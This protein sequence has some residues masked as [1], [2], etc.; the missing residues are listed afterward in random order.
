MG[1]NTKIGTA[2]IKV[3]FITA[4]NSFELQTDTSGQ[5]QDDLTTKLKGSATNSIISFQTTNEMQDDAA[6]FRLVLAPED[7]TRWDR[8][9]SPNDIVTIQVNPGYKVD[10]DYIMVGL[11]DTVK[12]IGSYNEDSL[13]Y[14]IEGKSMMKALMQIKLGTIQEAMSLLGSTGWM[15]GMGGLS[16]ANT[17]GADNL[18]GDGGNGGEEGGE[19]TTKKL[20]VKALNDISFMSTELIGIKDSK[21]KT[22]KPNSKGDIV[23][24]SKESGIKD[25]ERVKVPGYGTHKAVL[26]KNSVTNNKLPEVIISFKDK[27]RYTQYTSKYKGEQSIEINPSSSAGDK[28]DTATPSTG[29]MLAGKTAHEVVQELVNW[30]L[31]L[32]GAGNTVQDNP[33]GESVIKYEYADKERGTLSK[34]LETDLT[35]RSEDEYLTDPTPIMSYTG[36]LR[37]LIDDVT[38]RP[39]NELYNEFTPDGKMSIVMRPTPFE[40]EQW[41]EL[42]AQ[43]VPLNAEDVIEEATSQSDN[44]AFSIFSSS[45]PSSIIVSSLNSLMMFPVYY[46][47]LA[48]RYGYSMLQQENGYIF[49]TNPAKNKSGGGSE[50]ASSI[51]AGSKDTEKNAKAIAAYLKK[52][53]YKG[54]AIAALL[55][56]L[57]H[58]SY[59]N[60]DQGEAGNGIGYGIAQW[61]FERRKNLE[62]YAKGKGKKV[63]DLSV[64]VEFMLNHDGTDSDLLRGILGKSGS[65]DSLT[66]EICRR[67]ER[68]NMAVAQLG[69]RQ[70]NAKHWYKSL[71]LDSYTPGK[72]A[73]HFSP[74][75]L[76]KLAPAE[77]HSTSVTSGKNPV[78]DAMNGKKPEKQDDR[79]HSILKGDGDP[80]R[81]T[82]PIE[83]RLKEKEGKKKKKDN[84]KKKEEKKKMDKDNIALSKKYSIFLANWYGINPSFLSGDI[85]VIGSPIYRVGQVLKRKD[86]G[87]ADNDIANQELNPRIID[88]YIEGVSH[89]FNFEAGYTT[90]LHVTRGLPEG[91]TRDGSNQSVDRFRYWND[92]VANSKDTKALTADKPGNG[93]LQLFTGGLFGEMSIG[94]AVEY[95]AQQNGGDDDSGDSSSAV[96]SPGKDS[97]PAKWKNAAQDSTSDDWGYYNRECVSYVAWKLNEAG[98]NKGFSHLGNAISWKG[99]GSS[100]KEPKA[101]DVAWFTAGA[102]NGGVGSMGHVGYVDKVM[103]DKILMSDYNAGDPMGRYNTHEMSKDTPTSY[104]RFH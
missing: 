36:S 48:E 75:N 71:K 97:Y 28:D 93:D 78:L 64:Q 53:G 47:A 13:L 67:W 19:P 50:D 96:A 59:I 45:M 90:T 34:W 103:G 102:W 73:V 82:N 87:E 1:V 58:E 23:M 12:K 100:H 52:A 18:E 7:G 79:V 20:H 4:T 74:A 57:Q 9:L 83:D 32:E 99:H 65:V 92:P 2:T 25:G 15:M 5:K 42:E 81:P 98:G 31:N 30:F 61:S 80:N 89:E 63:S 27:K 76:K 86:P 95:A 51:G 72:G 62:A 40:P 35:S 56:N 3:K 29:L 66:E 26:V 85:R 49:I 10:N 41:K 22:P 21:G 55:G 84:G 6:A 46:P 8:V 14:Q 44:E 17:T 104:L 77:D 39:Y 54:A 60:P 88:Y 91:M 68:P 11:V 16:A 24:V 101:G 38:A 69:T 43:A 37:K 70:A 33:D 94:D